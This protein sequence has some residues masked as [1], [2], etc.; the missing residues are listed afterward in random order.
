MKI[1]TRHFCLA[2]LALGWQAH[3]AAQE[4]TQP[5]QNSTAGSPTQQSGY[6][7]L[8]GGL[9][10]T[11]NAL[12]S[13]SQR[14]SD[15]IATAG[16]DA[17]YRR[18]GELSLN[19]LGNLARLE[20]FRRS[21]S[22]SFYGHFFGLGVLGKPTD[23]LQWQLSDS[24]GEAMTDPL[25]APTPQ[26]LQTINQVATGPL[27]NLH[28]GLTNRLTLSGLYSRTT[29]QRSPFDSQTYKGQVEF[30]HSLPGAS[31]LALDAST[32]HTK[33]INGAAV[34][35]YLAGTTAAAGGSASAAT[36]GLSSAS[37]S[38]DIR[39]ASV[40]YNARLVRTEILLR[41]GYNTLQY[42]GASRHGAPLYEVRLSRQISPFSTVFLDGRQM[43]STNGSSLASPGAAVGLQ[44]GAGQNP[45]YAVAQPFNERS[46]DAGWLFN[47]ARTSLSLTGTY[48]QNVFN[49]TSVTNNNNNREEGATIVF[50]RQLRPTVRMQLRAQG[51]WNRYSQLGAQTRRE[52]FELSFSKRFARTM[53]WFYV[54]RRHQSGSQ[55]ISTFQASSYN[56]DRVGLFVTFDL[57]GER[58]MQPSLQGMPGM[59]SFTGGY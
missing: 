17:N 9:A 41:A 51:F 38:Y 2:M 1:D 6:V 42:G 56:D 19:L 4:V 37:S 22:G 3:A 48:R 8:L 10:Y 58:S 57:F 20:Y 39:Q 55:G 32:A 11:D 33:Y 23:T 50:G 31:S 25:S 59:G 16:F 27:V 15:G 49:Q 12:L 47:R 45:G 29:Y 18:T 13:G 28:F 43:Y 26:N 36:P 44:I 53:I 35:S 52:I 46:A 30:A 5:G 14:S 7:D 54:Q 21:Y 24:F 34:Q 40:S